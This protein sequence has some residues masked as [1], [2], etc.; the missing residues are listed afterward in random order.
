M[1]AA[2]RKP[3]V[4]AIL[5]ILLFLMIPSISLAN[6]KVYLTTCCG[7]GA[8]VSILDSMMLME[9]NFVPAGSG[10]TAIAIGPD[11]M[12]GYLGLSPQGQAGV[13]EVIDAMMGT[14]MMTFPAGNGAAAIAI[15][16]DGSTGYIANK[17]DGSVTIFDTATGSIKANL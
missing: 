14:V 13:V 17:N 1:Y 5:G 6:P 8:T 12:T 15:T 2:F 4:L 16:P 9:M 7:D 10:T 3:S 11:S